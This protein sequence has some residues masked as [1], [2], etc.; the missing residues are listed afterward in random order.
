MRN[1]LLISLPN[2]LQE[3]ALLKTINEDFE[4]PSD[5]IVDPDD[6]PVFKVDKSTPLT[7]SE[8]TV[9]LQEKV[10]PIKFVFS[11][12]FIFFKNVSSFT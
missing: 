2:F 9:E 4:L 7:E 5:E 3:I 11:L 6:G 10:A 8:L 1:L 12:H